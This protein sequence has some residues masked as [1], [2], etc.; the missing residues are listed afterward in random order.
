MDKVAVCIVE[1]NLFLREGLKSILD[2][3]DFRVV[4]EMPDIGAVPDA[5]GYDLVILSL[6]GEAAEDTVEAVGALKSR[7]PDI[8]VLVLSGDFDQSIMLA[9]FSAGADG[10]L[11]KS[12]SARALIA[13]MEMIMA[14]E[15][16][17]PS[18]VI[19]LI[20]PAQRSWPLCEDHDSEDGLDFSPKA[21]RIIR[22]LAAGMSNKLIA[23]SLGITEATV[24]VHLKAILRKLELDNRTQVAIWAVSHGIRPQMDEGLPP[25]EKMN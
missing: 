1:K 14:G 23:R 24:K 13:S 18:S 8:R 5:R 12:V 6:G 16:V 21:I 15:K 19:S 25:R 17:F 22:C 10:V 20:D 2:K 3:S 4:A 9:S 11:L 7:T